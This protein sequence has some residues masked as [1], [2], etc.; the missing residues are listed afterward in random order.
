M[1]LVPAGHPGQLAPAARIKE[2]ELM[3]DK[4]KKDKNKIQKQHQAK[5]QVEERAKQD[6]QPKR[7][8]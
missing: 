2:R 7:P 8:E 5:N 6:K 4:G 3:G 1:A